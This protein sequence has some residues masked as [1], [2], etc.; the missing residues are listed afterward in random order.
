V[1]TTEKTTWFVIAMILALAFA[2]SVVVNYYWGR[3]A[4]IKDVMITKSTSL[5]VKRGL[6]A[7][8]EEYGH[9]PIGANS[10]MMKVLAGGNIEGQN[11]KQLTFLHFA[12]KKRYN[13]KGGQSR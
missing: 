7:Y 6:T 11:P 2:W 3:P 1:N 12:D 8:F 5:N 10:N 13:D 9:F 4:P